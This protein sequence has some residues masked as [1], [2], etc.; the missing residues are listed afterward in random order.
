MIRWCLRGP[1]FENWV[2][3]EILK[4]RLH[5]GLPSRAYFLRDRKGFEIDLLLDVGDR[6]IATEIK[7]ARTV[8]GGFFANLERLLRSPPDALA[9]RDIE[10]R[11]VYGGSQRQRRRGTAVV[12]WNE[13][14]DLEW[15]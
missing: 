4:A 11:I 10:P 15:W 12:P 13:M 7:S 9:G 3:G 8:A 6:L 2:V 1:L 5:R 14:H